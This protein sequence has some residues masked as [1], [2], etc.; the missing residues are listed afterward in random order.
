MSRLFTGERVILYHGA[1]GRGV[2]L[3]RHVVMTLKLEKTD[4]LLIPNIQVLNSNSWTNLKYVV[5][6]YAHRT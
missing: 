6:L 5:Y 1:F 2:D 4:G 3:L